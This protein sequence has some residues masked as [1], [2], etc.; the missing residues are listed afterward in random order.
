LRIFRFKS[1]GQTLVHGPNGL[2]LTFDHGPLG[3]APLFNHGHADALSLTLA[4][5]GIPLLIDPGTF[6]YNGVPEW[7][8]YFKSTRAH[9]TVTVDGQDQAV[10]ET[11]FI[12]SRPYTAWP[13][14]IAQTDEGIMLMAGHDGYHRLKKPVMHTRVLLFLK[15]DWVLVRD[16]FEGRG[17][18]DFELNYHLHPDAEAS[19]AGGRVAVRRAGLEFF[20]AVLGQSRFNLVRGQ[21]EPIHG[22]YSPAYGI[23]VPATVLSCTCRGR[24]ADVS[25]TTA[26]SIGAHRDLSHL[27]ERMVYF[28][29]KARCA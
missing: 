27:E 29:Q 4:L 13:K 25:F 19:E 28:E 17:V 5:G 15:P 18:H 20:V 11:G 9:N 14:G 26:I 22:W 1:T 6:R 21:E 24:P 23:K 3:M 2:L 8:R 12:W 10:Q 7:R 16:T